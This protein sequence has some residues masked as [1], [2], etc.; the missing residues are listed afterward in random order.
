[1][2]VRAQTRPAPNTTKSLSSP[3]IYVA[4][5]VHAM[6]NR[7]SSE[8][9]WLDFA[10]CFVEFGRFVVALFIGYLRAHVE[11]RNTV[12]WTNMHLSWKRP[13][14]TQQSKWNV[15]RF[16]NKQ[17][18]VYKTIKTHGSLDWSSRNCLKIQLVC[19]ATCA[20]DVCACQSESNA[21]FTTRSL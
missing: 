8:W 9:N 14:K 5:D 18:K 11:R 2:L 7:D 16:A 12:T 19:R 20:T 10:K 6:I 1:M 15:F 13:P 4:C 3:R 21:A 17:Q